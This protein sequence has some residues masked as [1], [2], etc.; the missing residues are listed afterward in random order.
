MA[1]SQKGPISADRLSTGGG[2][3][4]AVCCFFNPSRYRSRVENY[5]RF[6]ANIAQSGIPLL[7]VELAFGGA[8]FHLREEDAVVQIRGGDVMWQ[9]ER[10]LRLGGDALIRAGYRKLVLL[11]ADLLFDDPAW[12]ERVAQALDTLPAVQCFSVAEH[13]YADQASLQQAI[14][15][16]HLD[17]GVKEDVAPGLAWGIRSE[18]FLEAGLFEYCVV[19]GGDAAFSYAALGLAHGAD[20]WQTTLR[21]RPFLRETGSAMLAAYQTWARRFSDVTGGEF[22]YVEGKVTSLPHGVKR[23]RSY[24][25]RHRLLVGFDPE[26]ELAT[27]GGG[28]FVWT[29]AG[30]H[31]REGVARYFSERNEDLSF[32]K[33]PQMDF[34]GTGSFPQVSSAEA[35]ES[36]VLRCR[37]WRK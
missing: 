19:G 12:A 9:K 25:L 18:V 3:I 6:R 37:G 16:A 21:H 24:A 35:C 28:A 27:E 8:P 10:L 1:L 17:N 26:R 20:A 33:S 32:P 34:T 13:R 29:D 15:F 7:T 4:A 2:E 31:R 36:D 14:A 22:G 5:G 11:D 23:D 30:S